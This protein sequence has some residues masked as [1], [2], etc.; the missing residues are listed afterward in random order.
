MLAGPYTRSIVMQRAFGRGDNAFTLSDRETL[1]DKLRQEACDKS[2]LPK[3]VCGL[4]T[5]MAN[6]VGDLTDGGAV[7]RFWESVTG[8]L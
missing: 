8:K 7:Q 5:V 2:H 4:E 3:H 1:P 6:S